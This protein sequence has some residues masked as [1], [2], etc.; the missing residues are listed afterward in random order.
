MLACFF[1]GLPKQRR[2]LRTGLG[3]APLSSRLAGV[4]RR[5][6]LP[7]NH[8]SETL[9]AVD[10]V[11]MIVFSPHSPTSFEIA[12]T[13]CLRIHKSWSFIAGR[14]AAWWGCGVT[15]KMASL[16]LGLLPLPWARVVVRSLEAASPPCAAVACGYTSRCSARCG[17]RGI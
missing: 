3:S 2:P 5:T 7:Q 8:G 17:S 1:C 15:V 11:I 12:D 10:M 13:K 4:R 9:V 16:L 6:C 14:G